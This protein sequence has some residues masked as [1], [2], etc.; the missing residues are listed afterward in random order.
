MAQALL[1]AYAVFSIVDSDIRR[2]LNTVC[3][4]RCCALCSSQNVPIPSHCAIL[5]EYE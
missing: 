4:V 1:N 2:L 5:L 3:V